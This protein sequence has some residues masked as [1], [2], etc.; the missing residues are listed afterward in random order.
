MIV[1]LPS[2]LV[3]Y[4]LGVW[5][6]HL[7]NFAVLFRWIVFVWHHLICLVLYYS[8]VYV[9]FSWISSNWRSEN[10]FFLKEQPTFVGWRSDLPCWLSG[11][12]LPISLG[13]TLCNIV[14]GHFEHG[15][16]ILAIPDPG[17]VY[18]LH[19]WHRCDQEQLWWLYMNGGSQKKSSSF[20]FS[21]NLVKVQD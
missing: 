3:V 2:C 8:I 1:F 15:Y 11:E 12:H 19:A 7:P 18:D 14:I 16:Y 5:C 17:V 4:R 6:F 21:F 20:P 13:P 9:C 10:Q